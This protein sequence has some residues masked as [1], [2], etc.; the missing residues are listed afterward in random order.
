[1]LSLWS[2]GREIG[3]S[4]ADAVAFCCVN[5][6]LEMEYQRDCTNFLILSIPILNH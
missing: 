4:D 1:M 5:L 2:A 6:G 3:E